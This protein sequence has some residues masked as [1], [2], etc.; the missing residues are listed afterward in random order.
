MTAKHPSRSRHMRVI[1]MHMSKAERGGGLWHIPNN[2][3]ASGIRLLQDDDGHIYLSRSSKDGFVQAYALCGHD[4]KP[5]R[6][7]RGGRP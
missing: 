5:L 7:E 3:R 4:D 1:R 2:A 6:V